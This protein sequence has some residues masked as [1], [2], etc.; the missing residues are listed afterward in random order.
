VTVKRWLKNNP[1]IWLVFFFLFVL[2]MNAA[3]VMIAV[4]QRPIL[5]D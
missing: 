3:F 5:V 1:W 4:Y 2:G